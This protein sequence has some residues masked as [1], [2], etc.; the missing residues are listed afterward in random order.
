MAKLIE[1]FGARY[2][3][4]AP[5]CPAKSDPCAVCGREVKQDSPAFWVVVVDGGARFEQADEKP[6]DENDPGH[7]GLHVV[8]SD[9][10][11]RLKAQGTRVMRT[12]GGRGRK[13]SEVPHA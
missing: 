6:V 8:G 3:H 7:M 2:M 13:A 1:P 4:N 11:R 9:C 10:A 12:Q 5:A